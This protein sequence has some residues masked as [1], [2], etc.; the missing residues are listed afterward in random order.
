[1]TRDDEVWVPDACNLPTAE[2]PLRLA[3][4]DELFATAVRGVEAV[5]QTHAR[6]SLAGPAGLEAK[7]RDLTARETGCC[8]FFTFT[9]TR[10][11]SGDGE[12]MVLDIEVPTAYANVLGSLAGRA[13]TL[14]AGATS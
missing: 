6:L 13:S 11:P 5:S 12:A 3:E 7:V 8:S 2:R 1:M 14:S 4:F 9:I 10:E